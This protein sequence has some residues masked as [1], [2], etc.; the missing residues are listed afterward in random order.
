[1]QLGLGSDPDCSCETVGS[2]E[3]EHVMRVRM[4]PTGYGAAFVEQAS[5]QMRHGQRV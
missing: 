2:H 5:V 3:T 1:M 4:A